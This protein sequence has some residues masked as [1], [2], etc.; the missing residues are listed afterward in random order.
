[1]AHWSLPLH[2][3]I[4][5]R[6]SYITLNFES[7]NPIILGE[8]YSEWSL[9]ISCIKSNHPIIFT[10]EKNDE[11]PM[12]WINISLDSYNIETKLLKAVEL[13]IYFNIFILP[14]ISSNNDNLE[15]ILEENNFL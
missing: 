13:A 9:L 3:I 4:Y 12:S 1:M 6:N 7:L 10:F 11:D 14:V 15:K 5:L 8:P 2:I